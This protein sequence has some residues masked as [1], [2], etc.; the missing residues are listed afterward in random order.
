MDWSPSLVL[1]LMMNA[2]F[3]IILVCKKSMNK[4]K[5]LS[6]IRREAIVNKMLSNRIFMWDL[7]MLSWAHPWDVW[8]MTLNWNVFIWCLLNVVVK[9]I[10]WDLLFLVWNYHLFSGGR[11]LKMMKDLEGVTC[12]LS[13]SR[14]I[15]KLRCN[16]YRNRALMYWFL[17]T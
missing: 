5:V 10:W 13:P 1:V 2:R 11:M 4:C 16:N 7:L 9:Q 3:N 8:L 15:W 14:F 17:V 12:W 6:K